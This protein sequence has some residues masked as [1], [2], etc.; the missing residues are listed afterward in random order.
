MMA[1]DASRR[2]TVLFGG[3]DTKLEADTWE[4][5]GAAWASILS[6][7]SPPARAF[8]ALAYDDLRAKVLLFGGAGEGASFADTWT[9]DGFAW[10]Q[11]VDT[12]APSGRSAHAMVYDGSNGH[13]L[14]F[15]GF[16]ESVLQGDTWEHQRVGGPCAADA[17]CEGRHCVDGVCCASACGVCERCDTPTPGQCAPVVSAEDV[18]TCTG[19]N[20]CD[21]SGRCRAKNGQACTSVSDCVSGFCVDGV[22]CATACAQAC[23]ACRGDLTNGQPDGTCAPV[24]NGKDPHDDCENDGTCSCKRDGACNGAGAC[25]LYQEGISCASFGVGS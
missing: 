10:R 8:G 11:E 13:L 21:A 23:Q 7:T 1:Y 15:A 2:K 17:D 20:A 12:T 4:W 3:I 25:R 22:C 24:A 5:D 19:A 18:I 16:G 6:P 14:V 9:W